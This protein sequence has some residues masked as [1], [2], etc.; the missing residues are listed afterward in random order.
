MQMNNA[1]VTPLKLERKLRQ[2]VRLKFK[3]YKT[4]P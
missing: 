4:K 3:R 1:K 2:T